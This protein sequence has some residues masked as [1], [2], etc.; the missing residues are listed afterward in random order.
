MRSLDPDA[1]HDEGDDEES[2]Q[3]IDIDTLDTTELTMQ[4][5]IIRGADI[6]EIYLPAHVNKFASNV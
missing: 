2:Q 1:M 4:S 6:V 3:G 5:K